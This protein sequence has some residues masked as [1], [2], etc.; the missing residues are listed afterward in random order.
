M[1]APPI[2]EIGDDASRAQALAR[3]AE[4]LARS[5]VEDAKTDARILLL[6]AAE[7]THAQLVLDPLASIGAK[8][9][10]RL[11][12]Y[13]A[14][15]AAREPVS[16]ILATRGFWTLDLHV[17]PGVLDPRA[18]TE[19]LVELALR[20]VADRRR[21]SLSILD[22]GSG[23]GAIVCALLSEL[24][25]AK[26]VAVDLSE[27]ACGATKANLAACGLAAR[28]T[29]LRGRWAEAISARFDLVVS[30]P[31]Y[32]R[33]EDIHSLSPEVALHDPLLALD[34]GG[35]GLGCYRQIVQ[36]LPNVLNPEGLVLFELGAGQASDVAEL[37]VEAGLQ[38]A[39][40]ARDAG[41]HERAVAARLPPSG[42]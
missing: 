3:V 33:S 8:A 42:A 12:E 28:G 5:G 20:L 27:T 11:A 13:A 1:N 10:R 24:P 16:R 35:D 30:N 32:I 40:I 38:I 26:A 29:V 39:A 7:L 17:T 41:G 14:R 37:L 9:A 15:R 34:G 18:D 22:L 4:L 6:A 31:P 19:T 21:E 36:G 23:S 25:E 2:L